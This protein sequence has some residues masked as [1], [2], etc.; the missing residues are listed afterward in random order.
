MKFAG[1]AGSEINTSCGARTGRDGAQI[2]LAEGFELRVV[3]LDLQRRQV[4]LHVIER[5]RAGNRKHRRRPPKK[6]RQLDLS[7]C[8][9]MPLGDLGERGATVAAQWKER[10]EH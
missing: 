10:Y 6:P 7:R 1:P 8:R 5:Q 9:S 4:L 2:A 3:Q